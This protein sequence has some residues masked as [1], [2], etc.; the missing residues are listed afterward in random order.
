MIRPFSGP[1]VGQALARPHNGFSAL[2][3]ALALM[4]VVSHA[5]SVVSGQGADEPLARSTGFSLGEHA[6][7]GFFAVSGFLVTMSYDRRG[8]RDYVIARSLRILPGLVAAT[9]AVSLLLGT[10]LTRL[11]IAEYL[12]APEL[13]RFV[14]GT[15]L[16]FKSNASLPGLFEANPLRSPLGTVW[17]LKYETICYVGVLVVGLCGLLRRRWAVPLFTAAL[18]LALA[19]LEAVR[20]EMSKGTETALRLPLIFAFGA[21]LYLWRDRVRLS[22]WPLLGLAAPL[23]LQGHAPARTLLFLSE[24]YAA[25]WLAFLPAL[26]RPALDPPADL[27]YGVYLYGWPIQQSLH[28][29]FPTA[30]AVALLPPALLLALLVAALSWYAIEKPALRLKARALGRRTLGT[31]EPAAP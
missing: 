22:A 21:C 18:A 26:A 7:N 24:S 29:L 25:I 5:F 30:S 16:S 14:R 17:T 15:L 19:T 20:P 6:V 2:R 23:L 27:S 13:W 8:W 11:P 28:A 9:L 4:V 1:T 12:A 31:I 10:A 3:L